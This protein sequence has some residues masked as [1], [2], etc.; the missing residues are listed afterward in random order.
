MGKHRHKHRNRR[1][2]RRASQHH[3][4]PRSRGGHKGTI[5]GQQIV[6]WAN[7]KK[8]TAWHV[9]FDNWAPERIFEE[10]NR[11]WINQFYDLVLVQKLSGRRL[12]GFGTHPGSGHGQHC[13]VWENPR[14]N[15]AWRAL[16][17]SWTV[18]RIFEEINKRRLDPRYEIVL[19]KKSGESQVT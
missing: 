10:I 4:I 11:H 8:H 14:K 18:E 15:D 7:G 3:R 6:V 16:F 19:V 2:S 12:R 5:F 17:D 9:L 1:K 13:V